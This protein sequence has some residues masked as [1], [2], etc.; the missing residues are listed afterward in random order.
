MMKD[1]KCIIFGITSFAKMIRYYVEKYSDLEVVAYTVDRRYKECDIFDGLPLIEFEEIEKKYCVEEYSF[2]LALGYK[3]M[4][5]IRKQK[6]HAVKAKGY[7]LENFIY[8]NTSQNYFEI[9]EGNII[10]ENV[11]LAYGVKIGNA[12]IIWNGCQ[13]SHESVIGDFNFFSVSSLIAG[14]TVVKNNCFLGVNSAV[15]GARTLED[16]TLVGAGCYMNDGSKAYGV[17]VPVRS[18]CLENKKSTDML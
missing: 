11:T 13:I 16:Y 6:Y 10:L 2:I 3:H 12:N 7:K 9:G 4:N 18:L 1:R 5:E 15:R 8:P 14:K 17:Y